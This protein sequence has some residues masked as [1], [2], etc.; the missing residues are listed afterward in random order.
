MQVLYKLLRAKHINSFNLYPF[1]GKNFRCVQLLFKLTTLKLN[2][3]IVPMIEL[4]LEK[5][6]RPKNY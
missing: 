1:V 2:G 5:F 4:T 6:S 3:C